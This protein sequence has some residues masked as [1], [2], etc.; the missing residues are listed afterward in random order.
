MST[1]EYRQELLRRVQAMAPEQGEPW[2][3]RYGA[4]RDQM[5]RVEADIASLRAERDYLHHQ[6][7]ALC[8]EVLPEWP[9]WRLP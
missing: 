9:G 1:A 3:E 5:D 2:L 6:L 7:D 4:L 8:R